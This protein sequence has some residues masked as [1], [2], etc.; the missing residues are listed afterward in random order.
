M[1]ED[2]DKDP[3]FAATPAAIAEAFDTTEPVSALA[4]E[5]NNAVIRMVA[6][7]VAVIVVGELRDKGVGAVS[8]LTLAGNPTAAA[9]VLFAFVIAS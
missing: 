5:V 1:P 8:K 9:I 3:L 2:A 6:G 4:M 7:S